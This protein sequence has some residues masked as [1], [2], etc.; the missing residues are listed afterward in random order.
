MNNGYEPNKKQKQDLIVFN[1][2]IDDILFKTNND[3]LLIFNKTEGK[4]FEASKNEDTI[5]FEEEF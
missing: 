3:E 1:S 2:F 4:F 5:T